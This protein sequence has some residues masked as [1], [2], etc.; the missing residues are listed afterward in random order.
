MKMRLMYSIVVFILITQLLACKNSDGN[1]NTVN[2]NAATAVMDNHT[3]QS[4]AALA[5]VQVLVEKEL[6]IAVSIKSTYFKANDTSAFVSATILKKDGS[7][8]DF[9]G[10]PFDEQANIGGSFSDDVFGLL[11][12]QGGSWKVKGISVG[13]TDVPF[14]C[15]P[16]TYKVSSTIFPDDIASN[17]CEDTPPFIFLSD[18]GRLSLNGGINITLQE[19]KEQ[20]LE[21]LLNMDKV[22]GDVMPEFGDKVGA[23][24]RAA[25]TKI[26][27]E[28]I[29]EAKMTKGG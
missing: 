29:S 24:S 2:Q 11:K 18:E 5:A 22:P 23:D 10:T 21:T 4:D 27:A 1:A 17:T 7:K 9:K 19:L 13:A 20:L 3:L 6:A 8:M 12:K 28:A 26:I 25:L 14:V 16:K 15:W